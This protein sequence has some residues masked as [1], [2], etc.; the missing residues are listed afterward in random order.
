MRSAARTGMPVNGVR[1][2]SP[3]SARLVTRE[4]SLRN[5][6]GGL[7]CS[8]M[9]HLV[10]RPGEDPAAERFRHA[11]HAK[12]SLYARLC[13]GNADGHLRKPRD[14]GAMI[15]EIVPEPE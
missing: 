8:A 15:F 10:R 5:T 3:M 2:A 9:Y 7:V 12:E 6:R 11:R 4:R 13:A 14:V 1:Q